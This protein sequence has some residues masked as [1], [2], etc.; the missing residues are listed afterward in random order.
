MKLKERT[1]IIKEG[2]ERPYKVIFAYLGDYESLSYD[3]ATQEE[4][5]KRL[6][7]LIKDAHKDIEEGLWDGYFAEIL[8]KIKIRSEEVI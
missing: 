1:E 2:K 4:A 7:D 3:F 6:E 8:L 5:E